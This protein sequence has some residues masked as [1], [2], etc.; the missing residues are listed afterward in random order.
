[1][2]RTVYRGVLLWFLCV[3]SLHA[4]SEP[5]TLAGIP[6]SEYASRRAE[7]RRQL[8]EDQMVLVAGESSPPTRLRF[9]QDNWFMYLSGVEV[10]GALLVLLP[11]NSPLEVKEVLFLPRQSRIGRIFEGPTLQPGE[12]AVRATGIQEVR[13]RSE[14][15]AFLQEALH[16]H[17]KPLLN[18]LAR[19]SM[20]DT[21]RE[22]NPEVQVNAVE[23]LLTPM[24]MVKSPTEMRLIRQAINATIEAHK[25]VARTLKPG[26]HEYELEA[27]IVATFRRHGCEGEGFPPIVGSGPNSC[28]LH[29]N[30]NKRKI[31]PGEL[32]LVDIGGEYSYYTADITRTYPASGKFTPRQRELY[33]AVLGAKKHA[34]KH[35]KPG[36]TLRQLHQKAVEYL[37]NSPLRAKDEN[38]QER[39]LDYFFVH[40]LSHHMGMDVHDPDNG[41]P[42]KPGMVFTIEPGI[43][44]PSEN[45]GIRIEDDYLMT[46]NGALNLC[47]ALPTEPQV[48][49]QLMAQ[50]RRGRK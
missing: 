33:L 12:E 15:R 32:V 24:R 36:I 46:E 22:L 37:R 39:T 26:I 18:R 13:D 29:Y 47:T 31:Q 43:Y 4:V 25:E 48:I 17:P 3:A 19:Q 1:M 5:A 11:E 9:R 38:G 23:P 10:A 28:I 16:H 50:G 42:L 44:I 35:A 6:L 41:A 45:I 34:E 40:A 2:K 20:L 27:V 30:A 8:A 7:L 14:L 49:E 21:L